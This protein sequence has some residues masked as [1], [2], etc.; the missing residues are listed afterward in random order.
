M[1]LAKRRKRKFVVAIILLAI[2]PVIGGAGW[3]LR[4]RLTKPSIARCMT[5]VSRIHNDCEY[6]I[7]V[8]WDDFG[9]LR[10]IIFEYHSYSMADQPPPEFIFKGHRWWQLKKG[11]YFDGQQLALGY[12][13][14]YCRFSGHPVV[15]ISVSSDEAKELAE[16]EDWSKE[17][18]YS[19]IQE[20]LLPR[21]QEGRDC[22]VLSAKGELPPTPTT[23]PTD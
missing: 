10:V 23:Q 6:G 15:E 1:A 12:P 4:R 16:I 21:L 20:S 22:Q 13:S 14:V 9:A 11:L 19:F 8:G 18:I 17:Q 2:L 5:W 7:R 3:W